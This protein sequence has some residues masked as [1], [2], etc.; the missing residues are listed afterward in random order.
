MYEIAFK[1]EDEEKETKTLNSLKYSIE[2]EYHLKDTLIDMWEYDYKSFVIELLKR[3]NVDPPPKE[4]SSS[5]SRGLNKDRGDTTTPPETTSSNDTE[6]KILELIEDN[7]TDRIEGD[8]PFTQELAATTSPTSADAAEFVKDLESPQI[9]E[10]KK[11]I[12]DVFVKTARE[13]CITDYIGRTEL[14]LIEEFD[15]FAGIMKPTIQQYETE[16]QKTIGTPDERLFKTIWELTLGIENYNG[17][18]SLVAPKC[19][20]ISTLTRIPKD[21]LTAF[22]KALLYTHQRIIDN[23]KEICVNNGITYDDICPQNT[24]TSL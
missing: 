21:E 3:A 5:K 20:S 13:H 9:P 17:L 11:Y 15:C 22:E 16:I 14:E 6:G 19:G 4:Q 1:L 12:L 24:P 7:T 10:L 2:M 23:F 8:S 18:V